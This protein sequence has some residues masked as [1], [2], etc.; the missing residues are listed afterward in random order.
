MRI[1]LHIGLQKTGTTAMQ[2]WFARKQGWLARQGVL[3][4]RPRRDLPACGPLVLSLRDG[5]AAERI[6]AMCATVRDN[7]GAGDALISSEDFSCHSPALARPLIEAF[8]GHDLRLLV[9][10]RRQDRLAESLYKQMIKFNGG[11]PSFEGWLAAGRARALDHHGLLQAWEREFP[12]LALHPRI[13]PEPVE[14]QPG[15]SIA[16]MLIALG[17]PD[18]IPDD[19][20]GHRANV[21]PRAELVGIYRGLP[22]MGRAVRRANRELMSRHGTALGGRGD[23]LAPDVA[24]EIMDFHAAGNEA[25]RARWFSDREDL[26][27]PMPAPMVAAPMPPGIHEELALLIRNETSS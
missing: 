10:L 17:R 20:A 6:D 11:G 18:L 13:H 2:A 26:F 22:G 14:G 1:W 8:H 4:L 25:V 7:P 19:S 27:D 12:E 5:T 23:L 16:A 21:S 24:A 15:D 9:W 3:Y